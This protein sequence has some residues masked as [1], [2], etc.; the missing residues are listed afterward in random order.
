M[1]TKTKVI[2]FGLVACV[3]FSGQ[4]SLYKFDDMNANNGGMS[5]QLESIESTYNTGS[6]QFTWDVVFNDDARGID[7][8][9][10]V[11]NNGPNPK[12][13]NVNELAIMYGDMESGILTTYA[14]NG[15]NSSNSYLNPGTLLQTDTFT[16]N[17]DGLSIDIDVSAINAWV[18]PD[19]DYSGIQYDEKVGIWFHISK[20][21]NF[22]YGQS[23]LLQQYSYGAQGWYDSANLSAAEVPEPRALA[24]LLFGLAGIGVYKKRAKS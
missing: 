11:V 21:S 8:F 24:L 9:W 19:R 1:Y 23:G 6:N 5:D 2:I 4:A 20:N 7:G 16:A 13:S 22:N 10:L 12:R 15:R 3:S 17:S 14:Y 18:S